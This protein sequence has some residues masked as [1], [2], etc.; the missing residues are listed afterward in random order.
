VIDARRHISPQ[1]SLAVLTNKPEQHSRRLLRHLGL[2]PLFFAVVG[3]DAPLP[4]KPDPAGLRRLMSDAGAAPATTLLVGD[5]IVDAETAR[6]AAVRLC[7]ARYGFG[8]FPDDAALPVGT[9]VASTSADLAPVLQRFLREA[10][11]RKKRE[12]PT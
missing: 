1:A 3:G 12:K 7:V 10:H 11:E 6:R 4:R 9:L 2:A 8:P 5:P